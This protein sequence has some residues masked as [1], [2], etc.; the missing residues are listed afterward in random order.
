M[1]NWQ[2]VKIE[3]G[4]AV[5][6]A[7][8][9]TIRITDAQNS[10]CFELTLFK[11]GAIYKTAFWHGQDMDIPTECYENDELVWERY[12]GTPEFA[13][14]LNYIDWEAEDVTED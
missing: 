5:F 3:T 14:S 13:E 2:I 8:D 9:L 10:G 11:D 4:L 1:K 7:D 12:F 6:A